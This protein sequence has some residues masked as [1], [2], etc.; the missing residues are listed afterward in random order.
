MVR[1]FV[2]TWQSAR[3][4]WVGLTA[5][6]FE[7]LD[8]VL[9]SNSSRSSASPAYLDLNRILRGQIPR[10]S[11]RFHPAWPPPCHNIHWCLPR[12]PSSRFSDFFASADRRSRNSQVP[13]KPGEKVDP[14]SLAFRTRLTSSSLFVVAVASNS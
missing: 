3:L 10:N 2:W 9:R 5:A 6:E 7:T 4:L 13:T 8:K 14:S 12:A 1:S 11:C